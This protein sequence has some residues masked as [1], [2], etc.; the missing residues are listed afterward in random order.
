MYAERLWKAGEARR[1]FFRPSGAPLRPP[2]GTEPSDR[3]VQTD[4]ARTLEC[5]AREGPDVLYRG[6]IA[7]AIVADVRASGGVLAAAD[8]ANYEARVGTPLQT[9]YRDHRVITLDGLSGGPTIARALTV[10]DAFRSAR[11]IAAAST[12]CIWWRRRCA[13]RSCTASRSAPTTRHTSTPSTRDRPM[14]ASR[15]RSA[16]AL[17]RASCQRGPASS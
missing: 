8:L 4:L 16:R 1:I 5:I 13:R 17:G 12:T 2:I 14:V 3:V 7:E 9:M 6:E 11:R 15:R 10:L